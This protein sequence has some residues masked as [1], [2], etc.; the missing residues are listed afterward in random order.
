MKNKVSIII[1]IYNAKEYIERCLESIFNQTYKNIEII[2][3][4]DG[5]N[6]DDVYI[7]ETEMFGPEL[8]GHQAV[9]A[10]KNAKF[11]ADM[12]AFIKEKMGGREKE[13]ENYLMKTTWPSVI[14]KPLQEEDLHPWRSKEQWGCCEDGLDS[15]VSRASGTERW[16]VRKS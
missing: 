4:N 7:E 3:I 15:M 5:S 14:L 10:K 6:F 1:P 16:E 2:A 8:F 13:A 12:T 9:V 11:I